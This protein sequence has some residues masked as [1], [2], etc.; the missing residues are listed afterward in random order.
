LLAIIGVAV[1]AIGIFV[2]ADYHL[3]AARREVEQGHNLAAIGHLMQI[4]RLRP[5]QPEVL[6]LSARVARRSGAWNEAEVLLD[7]Y[8]ELHGDDEALVL[9][10]LLLRATRGEAEA[11]GPILQARI[12]RDDPSAP[13]AREALVA[14]LLYRYRLF[15]ADRQIDAWLKR[16]PDSPLALLAAGQLHEHLEQADE[17]I[18]IYQRVLELDPE[19]D[20]VRLRLTGQLLQSNRTEEAIP[21]LQLLRQRLPEHTQVLLQLG[22][23]LDANGRAQEA[24]AALDECLRFNPEQ[25]AALAE[26]GRIARRDGDLTHAEQ[27]LY[28]ATHLDPGDAKARYQ[29]YLTLNELGKKEE[30]A[31]ELDAHGQ[32]EADV[33][34]VKDILL[35]QLQ[36]MPNNPA[37]YHE[38][39]L[40]ALRAGRPKEALRWLETALQVN[41][42][43]VPTHQTLAAFY[44][45]TGNPIMSARHRAIAARLAGEKTT[46]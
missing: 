16:A 24:I 17:A 34:R 39:A 29:F 1:G 46:K 45:E 10:R 30:A 14:G 15:D 43:H 6:L 5:D 36:Q 12:D 38:V 18:R 27:W 28:Q 23:A 7:R 8:T 20:E 4:R 13:L 3:R 9:E 2:W 11:A 32:I 40:I 26:R 41:P 35:N 22:Q 19:F 42:N 33:A 25:A 37:A 31:T 44:H 21:H